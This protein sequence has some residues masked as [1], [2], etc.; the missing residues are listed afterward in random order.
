MTNAE[1]SRQS[2]WRQYIFSVDHKVIGLQYGLTALSF[3]L[4]GFML[5]MLMRW[6]LAV[7]AFGNYILPLQIGAPDMAYPRFN[8]LLPDHPSCI[9]TRRNT[10]HSYYPT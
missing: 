3:L 2:F 10:P 8:T 7:G 6:Q 5:M 4:L 9:L 1:Y